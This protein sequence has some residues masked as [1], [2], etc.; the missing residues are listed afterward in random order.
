MTYS[1]HWFH[2]K[3]LERRRKYEITVEYCKILEIFS[4]LHNL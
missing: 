4:I 2:S 1:L 3:I